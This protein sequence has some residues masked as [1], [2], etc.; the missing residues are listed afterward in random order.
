MATLPANISNLSAAEKFDLLDALWEDLD[1]HA[2]AFS[3]E[4]AEELD[5]RVASY[6]MNPSAVVSWDQVKAGQPKLQFIISSNKVCQ[7]FSLGKHNNISIPSRSP[8]GS[9]RSPQ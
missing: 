5:R 2:P 7:G 8:N 1:A 9:E 3:A 4:Q 6:E